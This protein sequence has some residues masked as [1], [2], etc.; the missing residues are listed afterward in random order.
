MP[1]Y[2]HIDADA[3]KLTLRDIIKPGITGT[4]RFARR[5]VERYAPDLVEKWLRACRDPCAG[6]GEENKG[7][8][9]ER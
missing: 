5:D 6:A 2:K 8:K 9:K 1:M 7:P 4:V 3:M